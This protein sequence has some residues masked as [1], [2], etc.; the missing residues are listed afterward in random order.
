M[1]DAPPIIPL[2]EWRRQHR[3]G[4]PSP[5]TTDAELRA[6]VEEHIH[7]TPFLD[8]AKLTHERFGPER[9]VS[10]SA[11]SRHWNLHKDRLLKQS[12][13]GGGDA[14]PQ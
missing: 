5:F 1:N 9:G 7:T 13:P 6:F 11:I 12:A 14:E 2:S 3:R 4:K 10:K 8:L